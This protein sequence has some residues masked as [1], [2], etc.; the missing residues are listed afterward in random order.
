MTRIQRERFQ[1]DEEYQKVRCIN[2]EKQN[3][4]ILTASLGLRHLQS[5]AQI[6]AKS[7]ETWQNDCDASI[8]ATR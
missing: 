5:N 1:S 3:E 8:T 2:I 6:D 7:K 4:F